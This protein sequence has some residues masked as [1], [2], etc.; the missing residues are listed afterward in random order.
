MS[1]YLLFI[2][3]HIHTL[4]TPNH[5]THAPKQKLWRTP[6]TNMQ[7]Y[8]PQLCHYSICLEFCQLLASGNIYAGL[9]AIEAFAECHLQAHQA[10]GSVVDVD[11]RIFVDVG[12]HLAYARRELGDCEIV[13]IEVELR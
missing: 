13:G 2:P 3:Q 11:E 8:S 9:Q 10:T 5:G 6:H 1:E 7:E 12:F 4:H